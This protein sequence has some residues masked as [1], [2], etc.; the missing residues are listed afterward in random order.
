MAAGA[1]FGLAA[2]IFATL[3]QAISG[4]MQRHIAWPP[5]RPLIGGAAIA[6]VA[7]LPAATPYLGLGTPVIAQSLLEP[8]P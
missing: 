2:R 8:L 1:A 5:L 7:W 4:F 3:T 6:M